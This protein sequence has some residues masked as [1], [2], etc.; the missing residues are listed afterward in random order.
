M[1]KVILCIMDGIGI[2]KEDHGNAVRVANTKNL[3]MLIE[4]YPKSL[5]EA[6]GNKV[7]LP[8]GQ[9]GNSE[10]GHINIGAGRVVYQPLELLKNMIKTKKIF[11]NE[12]INEVNTIFIINFTTYCY[13]KWRR[14]DL[15]M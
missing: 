2:R 4:K 13:N 1:K 3:D 7:G 14:L 11:D 15:I 12:N 8:K 5:L 6:S 10:V 9:M